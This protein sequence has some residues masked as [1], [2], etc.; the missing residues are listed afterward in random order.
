MF[1]KRIP[2][3]TTWLINQ[4]IMMMILSNKFIEGSL[5]LYTS[6][7]FKF[8]KLLIIFY[9][10]SLLLPFGIFPIVSNLHGFT[11]FNIV[12]GKDGK[13]FQGPV[14]LCYA[15]KYLPHNKCENLQRQSVLTRIIPKCW[16]SHSVLHWNKITSWRH[17]WLCMFFS[18]ILF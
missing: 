9:W 13:L 6:W 8:F 3:C 7:T 5:Y 2:Y 4:L 11:E 15:I 1:L 16:S 12:V 17:K 10:D 14:A 18:K